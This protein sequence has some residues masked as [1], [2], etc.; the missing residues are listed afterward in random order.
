KLPTIAPAQQPALTLVL[1]PDPSLWDGRFADNAWLQECPR[2]LTH[3][4]WGNSLKVSP[5]DA[6]AHGLIDGD[7]VKLSRGDAATEAPIKIDPGQPVGV[8]AATL[9]SGRQHAGAIGSGIGFD[10][11]PVRSAASP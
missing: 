9:G 4:V 3:E 1:A 10:V 7:V 6:A 11:Y 2:P 8:V 5:T